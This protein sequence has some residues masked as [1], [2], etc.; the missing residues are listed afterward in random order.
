MY[1]S[2]SPDR[3]DRRAS[4]VMILDWTESPDRDS[5]LSMPIDFR[6]KSRMG[7]LRS[8]SL[9]SALKLAAIFRE[10]RANAKPPAITTEH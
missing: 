3:R 2:T 5:M 1:S 6:F 9:Y 10:V 8:G 4:R 7:M